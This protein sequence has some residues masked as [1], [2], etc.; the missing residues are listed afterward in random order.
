VGVERVGSLYWVF[1]FVGRWSRN[2]VISSLNLVSRLARLVLRLFGMCLSTVGVEGD[3]R[4]EIEDGK[5]GI[6][7]S[8]SSG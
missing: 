4:L 2:L 1:G 5:R 7:H 3:W 6:S 8:A